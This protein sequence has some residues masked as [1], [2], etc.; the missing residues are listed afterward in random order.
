MEHINAIKDLTSKFDEIPQDLHKGEKFAQIYATHRP[1]YPQEIYEK[2]LAYH[3][4]IP[5]N[6]RLLAVDVGCETGQSTRPLTKYFQQV[7]G[8]DVSE[9]QLSIIPRNAPNLDYKVAYAED[10]NFL[11]DKTV[12][13]VTVATALHW[14]DYKKFFS[15]ARRVLKPDGTLAV[16][17]MFHENF[18]HPEVRAYIAQLQ[19]T[20]FSGYL[21]TRFRMILE[22]FQSLEFP[23][24]D[25]RRHDDIIKTGELTLDGIVGYLASFHYTKLF[26]DD[27]PDRDILAEMKQSLQEIFQKSNH[28]LTEPV[29]VKVNWYY[30]VILCRN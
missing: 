21:T 8:S 2:I 1:T 29:K 14:M 4:E 20:I 6:K 5:Q 18:E 16:Y 7:I 25:I 22:K 24:K 11:G 28:H 27:N 9:D 30:F 19:S 3:S 26:A 15:E 13:M 10:L 23:F 17:S 12:D